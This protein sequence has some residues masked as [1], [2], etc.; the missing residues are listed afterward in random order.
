MKKLI[1]LGLIGMITMMFSG[2]EN[3]TSIKEENEIKTYSSNRK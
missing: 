1:S 2:C 3:P